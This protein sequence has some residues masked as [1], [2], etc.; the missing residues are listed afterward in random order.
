M[1]HR[2]DRPDGNERV[3]FGPAKQ[4]CS[5]CGRGDRRQMAGGTPAQQTAAMLLRDADRLLSAVLFW[6]LV[7]NICYFTLSSIC[8]IKI[9]QDDAL[10]QSFAVAF[11]VG[12]LLAIIFFSEM[13]PKSLAVLQPKRLASL[14]SIPLG[15]A[16]RLVDP[17]MPLLKSINLV[18]KRLFLP[19]LRTRTVHGNQ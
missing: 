3:L 15:V 5:T 10:G 2:D 7:I 11:A 6:N 12:S 18:S 17:L 13:L 1:V 16:V 4:P 19:W 14:L 9:D 8:A